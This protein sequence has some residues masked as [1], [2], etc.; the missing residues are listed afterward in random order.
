M[1]SL[2]LVLDTLRNTFADNRII[3]FQNYSDAVITSDTITAEGIEEIFPIN[4]YIK[5]EGSVFNDNYFKVTGNGT[6]TITVDGLVPDIKTEF[7]IKA[8]FIP[9]DVINF[10]SNTSLSDIPLLKS[11]S[12]GSYSYA[13]EK[14]GIENYIMNSLSPYYQAVII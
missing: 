4:C 12:I 11:E 13:T 7:C 9:D 14:E 8:C 2:K 5:I 10:A 1:I 3:P 6:D